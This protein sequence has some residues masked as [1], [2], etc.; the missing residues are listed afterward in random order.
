MKYK[1]R[2]APINVSY[3][4]RLPV[5][6]SGLKS[7]LR[8]WKKGNFQFPLSNSQRVLNKMNFNQLMWFSIVGSIICS[9]PNNSQGTVASRKAFSSRRAEIEGSLITIDCP[10]GEVYDITR[11]RCVE[12]SSRVR[13]FNREAGQI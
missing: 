5:L 8:L 9:L 2:A 10:S 4:A 13:N 3:K 12:L 11:E 6:K 7:Q 1:S